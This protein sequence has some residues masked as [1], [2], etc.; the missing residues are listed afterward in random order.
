MKKTALKNQ[1]SD[2]NLTELDSKKAS[3]DHSYWIPETGIPGG[4]FFL[5]LPTAPVVPWREPGKRRRN[6]TSD[7][8]SIEMALVDGRCKLG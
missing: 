3:E 8:N 5:P 7:V 2:I 4:T 6:E 1:A